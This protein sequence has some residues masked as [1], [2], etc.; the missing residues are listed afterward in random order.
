M[1]INRNVFILASAAFTH[2]SPVHIEF[3]FKF[4]TALVLALH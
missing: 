1:L 2:V 3:M 4:H